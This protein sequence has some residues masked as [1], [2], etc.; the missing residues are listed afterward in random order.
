MA[1][2][3]HMGHRGGKKG[4][5][6]VG[7]LGRH[8]RKGE[9]GT[10]GRHGRKSI[11]SKLTNPRGWSPAAEAAAPAEA[12]TKATE[13]LIYELRYCLESFSYFYH[14]ISVNS[15]TTFSEF[16]LV[17]FWIFSLPL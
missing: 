10:L 15:V 7:P 14:Y 6:G 8:G 13:N 2:G 17:L 1:K 3:L 4:G 5:G 16:S 11:K 9:R 12:E